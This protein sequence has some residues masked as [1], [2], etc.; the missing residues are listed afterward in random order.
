MVLLLS[1]LMQH[2]PSL[3]WL[4]VPSLRQAHQHS[5]V[6]N[7]WLS[8]GSLDL[9]EV[10]PFFSCYLKT[11]FLKKGNYVC[12]EIGEVQNP[13]SSGQDRSSH[14]T[15]PCLSFFLFKT[16]M[17]IVPN[18]WHCGNKIRPSWP[19]ACAVIGRSLVCPG[20][21]ACKWIDDSRLKTS[22]TTEAG[23]QK[24]AR[25]VGSIFK[26][27][28][29]HYWCLVYRLTLEPLFVQFVRCD[30]GSMQR[31]LWEFILQ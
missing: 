31:E 25:V 4:K 17:M 14:F 13:L 16:V 1:A 15:S 20:R 28:N 11:P 19:L 24:G 12:S 3:L 18:P 26:I 8:L 2:T 29:K 9:V 6:T 27:W 10:L 5:C 21:Q 23:A 22:A 7:L 30:M